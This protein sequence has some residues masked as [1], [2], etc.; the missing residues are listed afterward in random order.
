LRVA[1]NKNKTVHDNLKAFGA[2]YLEGILTRDRIYTHWQNMNHYTW[3]GE[4]NGQMPEHV[5]LYLNMQ[6]EWTQSQYQ[7]NVGD[8]YWQQ[9]YTVIQQYSGLVEGYNL[10]TTPDRRLTYAQFQT[11]GSF[12]DMFDIVSYKASYRPNFNKMDLEQLKQ[13]F[14][15][16]THCSAIIKL[17]ED[18]TDIFFGH[19][20][21]FTF[22]AMTRIY[23]EYNLEYS[24]PLVKSKSVT[25]SSYPG[26]LASNDDFLIT[27]EKLVAIETSNVIFNTKLYDRLTPK[28]LLCWQRVI[29]A[30]R[31]ADTAPEWAK[32]FSQYNSGTYNNQYMVL[33]LKQFD[34]V[35]RQLKDNTLWVVEQIPGRVES[36]DVT[37]I[38]AFGYWP[39]YNVPFFASIRDESGYTDLVKKNPQAGDMMDYQHCVRANIFRRDQT[40][41]DSLTGIKSILRYNNWKAD[42]LSLNNPGYA[43]ASRN[44]LNTAHS[45]CSGG[46]DSKASSYQSVMQGVTYIINGPTYDDQIVYDWASSQCMLNNTRDS[47][48]GLPEKMNF[49]WIEFQKQF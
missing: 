43:I 49:D 40:K 2:G 36:K 3:F 33:D 32:I 38:L 16:N 41:V 25:F 28:S 47:R 22:S 45:S 6:R 9:V 5:E 18:L 12:G 10:N 48:I 1:T 46:Y 34:P 37:D 17:K 14:M 13:F 15:K 23:K 20:S 11:I 21:W 26:N 8:P 30:N 31:L 35:G 42:P 44:D 24:N 7:Q 19:T 4:T 39:S 29:L 27:S